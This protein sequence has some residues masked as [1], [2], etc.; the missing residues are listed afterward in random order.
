MITYES[1]ISKESDERY[2]HLHAEAAW[3]LMN[4]QLFE[5]AG[6]IIGLPT[7]FGGVDDLGGENQLK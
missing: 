2:N 3:A 1:K 7:N 4:I 6:T 5:A